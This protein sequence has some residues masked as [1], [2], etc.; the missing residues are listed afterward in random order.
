MS[1]AHWPNR[2][3]IS[4]VTPPGVSPLASYGPT[5][6]SVTKTVIGNLEIDSGISALKLCVYFVE[7]QDIRKN[8]FD[9]NEM[10]KP[11]F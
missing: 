7:V 3:F 2:R 1:L 10:F 9:L 6:T 4:L 11:M 5:K 8:C